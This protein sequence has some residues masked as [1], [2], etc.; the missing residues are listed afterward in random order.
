MGRS[1]REIDDRKEGRIQVPTA[2]EEG[3]GG[4]I[5]SGIH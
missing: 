5:M 2:E 1:K 4:F 3:L